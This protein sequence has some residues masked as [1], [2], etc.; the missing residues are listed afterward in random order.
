MHDGQL[1]Q[2]HCLI[3]IK[4][5][6]K[7]EKLGV[8]LDQDLHNDIILQFLTDAYGQFIKNYHMYKLQNTLAER[9][10]MLATAEL[11]MKDSKSSI[12]L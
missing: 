7:L 5:L 1:I 3:M 10:N 6:K 9:M 4:D 11:S 2:D 8:K 12:L